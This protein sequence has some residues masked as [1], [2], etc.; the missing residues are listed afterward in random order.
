M[1]TLILWLL[2]PTLLL[3][4]GA[5]RSHQRDQYIARYNTMRLRQ[6]LRNHRLRY[7]IMR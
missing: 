2:V 4:I 5:W 7:Y 6:W 1:L 3:T